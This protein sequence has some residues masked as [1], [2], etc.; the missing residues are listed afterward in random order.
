MRQK[1]SIIG[2]A[3]VAAVLLAACGTTPT[4]SS[5]PN[6]TASSG[7]ERA[8]SGIASKTFAAPVTDV[9][10]AVLKSL[11]RLDVKVMGEGKTEHGW[12]IMAVD[13]RRV[14][15]IQLDLVAPNTTRMRV[16]LGDNDG[17]FARA[18][19]IVL[20]TSDVLGPVPVDENA[21]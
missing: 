8:V 21:A 5:D 2:C 7:A 19:E 14:I 1:L 17:E 20:Q 11:H 15:E 10:I 18:T 4:T 9:R 16:V 13:S 6:L 12:K 3:A